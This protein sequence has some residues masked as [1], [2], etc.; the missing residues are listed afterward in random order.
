M[1]I[2]C[3]DGTGARRLFICASTYRVKTIQI[4]QSLV[5]NPE[6]G[7][8]GMLTS[9]MLSY[10]SQL[11]THGVCISGK[12]GSAFALWKDRK[13]LRAPPFLTMHYAGWVGDA[14]YVRVT[15]G[16]PYMT[17]LHARSVFSLSPALRM[18]QQPDRLCDVCQIPGE[19]WPVRS[20]LKG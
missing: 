11:R 17:G 20:V 13:R 9:D 7:S 5:Y 12:L 15:M 19:E 1:V 10:Q 2:R 4:G 8:N 3:R 6:F 16:V 14:E 18:E